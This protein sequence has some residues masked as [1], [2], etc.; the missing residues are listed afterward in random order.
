MTQ[1]H[2]KGLAELQKFLDQLP[3]KMEANVMRGALRAGVKMIADEAKRLVPVSPPS[4]GNKKRYNAMMGELRRSIRVSARIDRKT[5]QI[6]GLL[7]VGNA[8]AWY[9]YLVEFG[10]RRHWI[11]AQI[12]PQRVTRRGL[13]T[14]SIRTMNRN[15][16]RGA[17]VIGGT[18]VGDEIIHPGARPRPFLR[19]ALDSQRQNAVIAVAE[20]IK[21]RLATKQGLDTSGITIEAGL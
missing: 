4:S 19:P 17:L 7:T 3:A 13:R 15:A 5:R 6:L 12:R 16:N 2:V 9:P 14:A 10:T 20:Y 11:K 8:K 18:F 1:M 21:K